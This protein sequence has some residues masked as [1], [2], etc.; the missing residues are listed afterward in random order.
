M[1]TEEEKRLANNA[2]YKRYRA[3]NKD[4]ISKKKADHRRANPEI[5]KEQEKK[6][7]GKHKA[8]INERNRLYHE[9]NKEAINARRKKNRL[10]NLHL[11]KEYYKKN[12]ARLMPVKK[13]YREQN[14]EKFRAWRRDWWLKH[15]GNEYDRFLYSKRLYGDYAEAHRALC[16]INETLRKR[17]RA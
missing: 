7:Y 10:E 3:R 12:K 11:E 15:G 13:K 5:Y 9:K 6:R 8:K 16:Q 17:K 1:R 14:K 4:M 2:A